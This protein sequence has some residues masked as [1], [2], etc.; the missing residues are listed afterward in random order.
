MKPISRQEKRIRVLE[1]KLAMARLTVILMTG[2]EARHV[3]L[4]PSNLDSAAAVHYWFRDAMERVIAI[5]DVFTNEESSPKGKYANCPL[6]GE[7]PRG[8]YRERAGY[9]YPEDLRRHLVD[10]H[11][12]TQCGVSKIAMD[13]A[14]SSI[15]RQRGSHSYR[16]AP[17][18][19]DLTC[20]DSSH[21]RTRP[22]NGMGGQYKKYS[23]HSEQQPSSNDL[24]DHNA[25][26][27]AT[28]E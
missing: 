2:E 7:G 14:L 26:H 15:D 13:Y 9:V 16:S 28:Q 27:P 20:L 22:Q 24:V 23:R 12:G 10:N 5:A 11:S 19:L 1:G 3:L 4:C 6:C 17:S 18:Q 25:N 21:L 8:L